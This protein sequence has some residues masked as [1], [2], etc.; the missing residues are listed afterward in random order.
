MV[1]ALSARGTLKAVGLARQGLVAAAA[2]RR[3]QAGADPLS[4]CERTVS[5]ICCSLHMRCAW[6]GHFADCAAPEATYTSNVR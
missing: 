1:N 5:G 3:D 4:E 6:N 2:S